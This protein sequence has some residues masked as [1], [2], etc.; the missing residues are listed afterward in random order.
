LSFLVAALG[1]CSGAPD[2]SSQQTSQ[3]LFIS[4]G[5]QIWN[6]TIPLCFYQSPWLK[7]DH[8]R[9]KHIIQLAIERTWLRAANI[10]VEWDGTCPTVSPAHFVRINLSTHTA[11]DGSSDGQTSN[12]GMAALAPTSTPDPNIFNDPGIRIWIQ[13]DGGSDQSRLEYVAVHEFGHVLGFSHEQDRQDNPGGCA[14]ESLP[15]QELGPYDPDSVMNYCADLAHGYLSE[16]DVMNVRSVYG[17][18]PATGD[19]AG[20]VNGDGRAD[21]ISVR[22]DKIHV[23]LSNG[24]QFGPTE[25]LWTP[26]PFYGSRE[27]LVADVNGDGKADVIAINNDADFVILSDGTRFNWAGQWTTG[28][29]YGSRKTLAAD[30]NGDGKADLIAVNNQGIFVALSTGSSFTWAGQWSSGPLYG[31]RVT[32][33]GDMN[34]D[35][36]A[37]IVT[38]GLPGWQVATSNGAGFNLLPRTGTYSANALT[39]AIVDANGDGLG[40]LVAMNAWGIDVSLSLANGFGP[41]AW[42]SMPFW[43]S[44]ASLLADVNGD[45]MVDAIAVNPD[46]DYVMTSSGT[47]WVWAGKWSGPFFSQ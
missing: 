16:G 26:G 18:R 9:E 35:G 44:Q 27:T 37:D 23:L 19:F 21:A 3:D 15:G 28:P 40:D 20:D 11:E 34:R 36:K 10:S 14:G 43:G 45:G 7:N 39:Q 1:G 25:Q 31:T 30:V 8:T 29:F 32:M 47:S 22:D 42:T 41:V 4:S 38:V 33:A 13:D 24:S 2:E 17:F 6:Q 46:G 5:T 12:D